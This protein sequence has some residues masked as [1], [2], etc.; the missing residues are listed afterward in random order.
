MD[1]PAGNLR[2]RTFRSAGW[3]LA[4]WALLLA[5][6]LVGGCSGGAGSSSTP[7]R[8]HIGAALAP[9]DG[10]PGPPN[11][12]DWEGRLPLARGASLGSPRRVVAKDQP[13][14]T[15]VHDGITYTLSGGELWK[16]VDG[17]S[18]A[19]PVNL[20]TGSLNALDIDQDRI[21]LACRNGIAVSDNLD[22]G[23]TW[24]F[25][26]T[27]DACL[28][29]DMQ[30]GY[31]WACIANWGS[32]SGPHRKTPDGP[33]VRC[34][35]DL[36]YDRIGTFLCIEAD[37]AD[38]NAATMRSGNLAYRTADAGQ[39]W[40]PEG[41]PGPLPGEF[42]TWGTLTLDQGWNLISFPV[43]RLTSL[44]LGSGVLEYGFVWD[45]ALQV[46]QPVHLQDME[47]LATNGG[48]GRGFWIY[49]DQASR[50]D[51]A[52]WPNSEAHEILEVNLK[53]GWCLLGYPF[54]QDQEVSGFQ[55]RVP[56]SS[57]VLQAL[58]DSA[59]PVLPPPNPGTLLYGCGY[60]YRDQ[61]YQT[62]DLTS[63][64]TTF[65]SGR[66]TWVYV[67]QTDTAIRYSPVAPALYLSR[68]WL[69]PATERIRYGPMPLVAAGGSGPPY[70]VSVQ[71]L[72]E[73]MWFKAQEATLGGVPD[74]SASDSTASVTVTV[75]DG[76]GATRQWSLPLA[77]KGLHQGLLEASLRYFL[78]P[79]AVG[80]GGFPLTA[81]KPED[82]ARFGYCNCAE[83]GYRIL[84]LILAQRVGMLTQQQAALEIARIADS[85]RSLQADPQQ[86]V[87]GLL[88]PYY[89]LLR[90]DGQPL[91]APVNDGVTLIPL[92]D[93]ALLWACCDVAR[94]WAMA[95][96]E[97]ALE[98]TLRAIQSGMDFRAI[99]GLVR[100]GD[101]AWIPLTVDA[102]DMTAQGRWA[103]FGDEGGVV[104]WVMYASGSVTLDELQALTRYQNR[105]TCEAHGVTVR[106]ALWF[107]MAF[108]LIQRHLAGLPTTSTDLGDSFYRDDTFLPCVQAHA[109][110]AAR[111]GMV[112]YL[113][114]MMS[115]LSG[116]RS[117]AG[118][119]W[120]APNQDSNRETTSRPS[121]VAS[122]AFVFPLA[123]YGA[124]PAD[125]RNSVE[126]RLIRMAND[127]AGY[128]HTADRSA[129]P[130][131]FE[132]AVAS[133]VDYQDYPGPDD[134]RG[135]F[136][137]LGGI[138]TAVPLY[139]A[140]AEGHGGRT[141]AAD[142]RA[143]P[144]RAQQIAQALSV[145]YPD[146][147]AASTTVVD[148]EQPGQVATWYTGSDG[149]TPSISWPSGQG[150]GGGSCLRWDYDGATTAILA[151]VPIQD[152]SHNDFRPYSRLRFR[153]KGQAPAEVGILGE[154][155]AGQPMSWSRA[156]PANVGQDW[157]E[158]VIEFGHFGSQV[159]DIYFRCPAREGGAPQ[160]MFLDDLRLDHP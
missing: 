70:T 86:N 102:A 85:I 83:P 27:W 77:V 33:W 99:G 112:G 71:G 100:S 123:E 80:A 117:L 105:T 14:T 152:G 42:P 150:F 155:V 159:V 60:N 6:L 58:T 49:T 48:T 103:N 20:D 134:G 97:S 11:L 88:Y 38:A 34:P 65:R 19:I 25:N 76:A 118:Q 21:Y 13:A 4:G 119:W 17:Q 127:L 145:F 72:P 153:I 133:T 140:W 91:A 126:E 62:L 125:T 111:L 22:G 26:W 120:V 78:A 128:L 101:Q 45:P 121:H 135:V 79:E 57:G 74:P 73:G 84:G 87:C 23:F 40:V 132:V 32:R 139:Q 94:G 81:L 141:F 55:V 8:Y 44:G 29:V 144:G 116:G 5:S 107:N 109:L 130:F 66:A 113:S 39:H 68:S 136:E 142:L 147:P 137:C 47:E 115:Q 37:P 138:Y 3:Y 12:K 129:T 104:A 18:T 15:A 108:T 59:S 50:I 149:A 93:N 106:D 9:G 143:V 35:G 151:C 67:Y 63:P 54:D 7:G 31:G 43:S 30:D 41:W 61:G 131:G 24:S 146:R 64:A 46:Y 16:V 51:Y 89:T 98:E 2:G 124:L 90:P 36:P 82:P 28:D 160:T 10:P 110:A 92:G 56:G 148:F 156:V 96:G 53:S 95:Q 122:H 154:T 114:D 75:A 52:G 69:P 1:A 157:E 158:K